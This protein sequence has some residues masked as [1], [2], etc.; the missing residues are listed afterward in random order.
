LL[1]T[2][3]KRRKPIETALQRAFSR[4]HGSFLRATGIDFTDLAAR[5][6]G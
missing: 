4:P 6:S 5:R 1:P 3:C 2:A